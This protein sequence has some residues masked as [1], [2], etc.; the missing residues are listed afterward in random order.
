MVNH[1][2]NIVLIGVLDKPGS[3]NLYMA[4]AFEK[5]GFNVIP[6]NY[7]TIIEKYGPNTLNHLLFKLS[8]DNPKL[9]L[10]SKFNGADSMVIGKCSQDDE[11]KSWFWFMDGINTLSKVPECIQ[12]AQLAT[13]S[14]FT[15]LGVLNHVK[16]AIGTAEGM[17]H[18]MEGID[19]DVYRPTIKIPEYECDIAFIGS[20]NPERLHYL[21]LLT[22]AGYKVKAYG[23]GFNEEIHGHQFNMVCSG[24]KAMLALSAEYNTQEYFSDR[25]FRYGA[26]G[27]FVIHKHAPGLDKYFTHQQDLAYFGDEDSLLQVMDHYIKQDNAEERQ[28]ISQNILDKVVNTHTWDNVIKQIC[29][30]AKI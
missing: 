6:V 23:Q 10:Y 18:I 17:F 26:C 27:S 24:A 28:A 22:E 4:K 30:I 15:G 2:G 16:K 5:A 20:V 12:H 25:V 9:M 13:F 29:S 14:S 19:Q 3:T 21:R 8:K 11:V 1:R 7:R